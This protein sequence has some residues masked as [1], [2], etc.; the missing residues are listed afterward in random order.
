M[1][2]RIKIMKFDMNLKKYVEYHFTGHTEIT[3]TTKFPTPEDILLIERT[4]NSH[5]DMRCHISEIE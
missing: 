1:I 3:E 4:I 5:T 2:Y